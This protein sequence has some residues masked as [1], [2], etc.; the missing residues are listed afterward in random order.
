MIKRNYIFSILL[1]ILAVFVT[2]LST[3]AQNHIFTT[4]PTDVQ[5]NNAVDTGI[6]NKTAKGS[7]SHTTYARL[8]KDLWK[9]TGIRLGSKLNKSD[10]TQLL[11][12]SDA[13]NIY[14]NQGD[15]VGNYAKYRLGL[16]TTT[17]LNAK[18]SALWVAENFTE[19]QRFEDSIAAINARIKDTT[20]RFDI[21]ATP[22]GKESQIGKVTDFESNLTIGETSESG[23]S[24]GVSGLVNETS[25]GRMKA[26]TIVQNKATASNA[27]IEMFE[28]A[29]GLGVYENGDNVSLSMTKDVAAFEDNSGNNAGVQSFTRGAF[30]PVAKSLITKEYADGRYP[31]VG[32]V[33]SNIN[34]VNSRVDSVAFNYVSRSKT[35][36]HVG[37]NLTEKATFAVN[38]QNNVNAR[39]LLQSQH[40]SGFVDL[41]VVAKDTIG[42]TNTTFHAYTFNSAYPQNASYDFFGPNQVTVQS[43][44]QSEKLNIVSNGASPSLNFFC[45]YRKRM[46]ISDTEIWINAP[47]KLNFVNQYASSSQILA[48]KDG[49]VVKLGFWTPS[50]SSDTSGQNGDMARDENYLYMKT[51]SGWKRIA[52]ATF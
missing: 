6:T 5:F 34:D 18:A 30:A 37:L 47:L 38:G 22:L 21:F 25:T 17:Q 1:A 23:V 8:L 7:V 32:Q 11:K 44:S 50:S 15:T 26:V 51:S 29:V 2:P 28:N 24:K 45:D 16:A 12:K 14:V 48:I 20:L 10:T 19:Q 31:T 49:E 52:W 46:V 36:E 4:E 35:Q 39:L 33:D 43:V 42:S 3:A 13:Q 9:W 40:R 41:K 27:S